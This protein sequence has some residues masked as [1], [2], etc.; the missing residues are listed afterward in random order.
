VGDTQFY[1]IYLVNHT[2]FLY[3]EYLTNKHNENLLKDLTY[4]MYLM[5]AHRSAVLFCIFNEGAQFH[6]ATWA[7]AAK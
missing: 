5:T 3:D 1:S 7:K 6:S 2:V 4:S